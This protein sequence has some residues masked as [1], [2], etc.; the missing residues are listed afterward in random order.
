MKTKKPC[1]KFLFLL[2]FLTSMLSFGQNI[3][4]GNVTSADGYPLP[5]ASIVEKG[6]LNGTQSDFDGNYTLEVGN[7]AILVVSYIGFDTKEVPVAGQR[8]VNITLSEN[9]AALDEVVVVGYGSQ[10]KKDIVSAVS[11]VDMKQVKDVPASDASRLL[12][13]QAPGVVVSQTS[14]R[15][16]QEM[17]IVVRGLSSLGATSKPLYVIDGFPVGNSLGSS[18]DPADIESITVLKDAAST[19]IYG[20]RGS[21]GV[22]LINT[23]KAKAGRTSVTLDVVSGFQQIPDGRREKMLNAQ[24]FGQFQKESW[25]DKFILNEGREPSENEIPE[26][27]RTPEQYTTSTDWFDEITDEAALFTKYNLNI[28]SGGEKTRSA[29][30]LGYLNQE[31]TI[32]KTNFERYNIRANIETDVTDDIR[33]GANVTGSRSN[34]RFVNDGSRNLVIGKA[35][36]ADP[37]EPVYNEDGSFNDYLGGYNR[38]GDLIFGHSN[39]VQELHEVKNTRH[40]NRLLTNAYVEFDFF[41]NF[42]FKSLANVSLIGLRTNNFRPSTLAGGG[43]NQPP[44]L[45]ASLSETYQEEVNW[46]TDQLLSYS[47]VFNEVHDVDV[48]L[49]YSAQE[50]TLREI[51]GTGSKFPDDQ[52]QFLQN[53]EIFSVNSSES[54]WSLL[55]YFAR[56]NYAYKDRYLLSA[57]Y[58]RE[59]SS[60]F[61]SNNR[62][63]SFPSVSVGWR[64][65]DEAFLQ[66]VYWL[67]DL[68]LRASYGITGNNN[69]GNYRSLSTLTNENYVFGNTFQPG[70][71]LSSLANTELGWEESNQINYG[72]DLTILDGLD[73]TAEYYKKETENMLLPVNIPVI[74]GFTSTFTNIGKVQNTGFEFALGYRKQII[75]DLSLRGNFNISFNRNKVLAINGDNDEIRNGGFYGTNNVSKVGRPIGMLH[76]FRNLGVFQNQAQIDASPTQDGAI[77]GSF[78]YFDNTGDGVVTYDTTDWVEIGN[79]HPEYVWAFTFGADY[80]AFDLNV[81]LTGAQNYDIYRNFESTSLNLDG[82]FN[83]D[84]RAKERFRSAENPGNGI[85]P[86]SNFWKWERESNSFYVHDASHMWIRNIS[87][88][89]N[90]SLKSDALF[91]NARLYISGD[92]LHVFTTFPGGNPQVSTAG[93]INPGRDDSAYP[94]PRSITLGATL[95]F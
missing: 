74:S 57:T 35:Y 30:S 63:G 55:A 32:I 23:K 37:R 78:I 9:T 12:L 43:F 76:G 31:G 87:L 80:K 93:G 59:G 85:V 49:G 53:S 82:V 2:A 84:V 95:S 58:R 65:S 50:A 88:G 21:N 13:G 27:I 73:F 75:D 45:D 17:D 29:I 89:Y 14:G 41:K 36:W 56:L 91:S 40:I 39:P 24:E 44:P 3:I 81:V 62:W 25:I 38:D 42:K 20:A 10:R 33:F 4:V 71:I 6:T 18:V 16:G 68:K 22:I 52:I 48:L 11:V 70:K 64:V 69:I 34:E 66:D 46:S 51:S 60:R 72:L 47:K 19:A 8:T 28:N 15:P 77:P 54:S 86:T 79:P 92:N 67:N 94:V 7:D 61:G 5:G 83:V 90:L 1:L 26:R